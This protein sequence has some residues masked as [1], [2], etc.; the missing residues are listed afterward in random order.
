MTKASI[1]GSETM[2]DKRFDRIEAKLDQ[3]VDTLAELA[4]IDEKVNSSHHRID[5]H[6][7]RLDHLEDAQRAVTEKLTTYASR[8]M[9]IERAAW[10]VFA[11]LVTTSAKF[12]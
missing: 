11:A 4:R 10:I 2:I 3:V 9:L 1:T 12:F 7:V 5:R 6:Q 8:G